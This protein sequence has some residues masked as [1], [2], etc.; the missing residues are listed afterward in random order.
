MLTVEAGARGH[1]FCDW[2][3]VG[4]GVAR[5]FVESGLG[6]DDEEVGTRG[7]EQRRHPGFFSMF[8]T[9][10]I[11]VGIADRG[12]NVFNL[13]SSVFG[14]RP[15]AIVP[16]VRLVVRWRSPAVFGLGFI[17]PI[18][19]ASSRR[20]VALIHIFRSRLRSYH[21]RNG[22]GR[23]SPT[24]FTLAVLGFCNTR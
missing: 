19:T 15:V 12:Q 18:R 23:Q 14:S 9:R 6:R 11:V 13:N 5:P 24:P 20:G 16:Y 8:T 2:K 17:I 7:A 22:A 10:E 4:A 3:L 21:Y 1:L